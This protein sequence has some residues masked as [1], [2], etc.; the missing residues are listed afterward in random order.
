MAL[1]VE[2]ARRIA[3]GEA[4]NTVTRSQAARQLGLLAGDLGAQ[5]S[6]NRSRA[7]SAA[8]RVGAPEIA[9][10]AAA[11]ARRSFHGPSCRLLRPL[12]TLQ[13]GPWVWGHTAAS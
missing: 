6:A 8:A 12:C 3:G 5:R 1:V 10:R 13:R 9:R 11:T 4:K 7:C 2:M